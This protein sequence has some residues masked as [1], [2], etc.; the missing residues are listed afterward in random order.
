MCIPTLGHLLITMSLCYWFHSAV[1]HHVRR[2]SL[3]SGFLQSRCYTQPPLR[4]TARSAPYFHSFLISV[5]LNTKVTTHIESCSTE[6]LTLPQ[7]PPFA[8][9][10]GHVVPFV[11]GMPTPAL[12]RMAWMVVYTPANMSPI[13]TNITPLPISP[14][15]LAIIDTF[16]FLELDLFI[17]FPVISTIVCTPWITILAIV[18]CDVIITLA[19]SNTLS[20]L[21]I[22]CSLSPVVVPEPRRPYGVSL[23]VIHKPSTNHSQIFIAQLTAFIGLVGWLVGSLIGCTAFEDIIETK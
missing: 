21:S 16:H 22:N 2:M 23:L 5:S 7:R 20:S 3:A 12:L 6:C 18:C 11:V 15:E 4:Y 8:I 13:A 1:A 17:S 14:S 10:C 19:I 9:G